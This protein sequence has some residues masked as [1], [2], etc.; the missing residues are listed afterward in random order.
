MP[1]H[2]TNEWNGKH[3]GTEGRDRENRETERWLHRAEIFF[4][5]KLG[6]GNPGR[7]MGVNP[8]ESGKKTIAV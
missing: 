3:I 1:E 5:V 6:W 8:P 2:A 4:P 7:R